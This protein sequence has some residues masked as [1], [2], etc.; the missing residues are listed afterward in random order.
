MKTTII[1][2]LLILLVC[3]SGGTLFSLN[4]TTSNTNALQRYVSTYCKPTKGWL[5]SAHSMPPHKRM[6]SADKY[7]TICSGIL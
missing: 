3:I 4:K 6:F 1:E 2:T 7:V 5:Y